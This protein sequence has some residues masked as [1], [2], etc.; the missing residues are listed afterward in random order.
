M[1]TRHASQKGRNELPK[2]GR[3]FVT[4]RNDFESS[5]ISLKFIPIGLF[6]LFPSFLY[7]PL[8]RSFGHSLFYA[9]R[10]GTL[11]GCSAESV[12][13]ISSS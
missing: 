1:K 2:A 9:T 11:A 4:K 6:V 7:S 13:Y 10:I 8:V 3:V 12:Q 5:T